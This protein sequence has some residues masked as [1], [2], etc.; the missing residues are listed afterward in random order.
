MPRQ[1]QVVIDCRD[2]DLMATFWAA[3]L[4]YQVDPGCRPAGMSPDQVSYPALT[5]EVVDRHL[6]GSHHIG[7]YPLTDDDTCWWVTAD[8]D[9]D[10]AML[11]AL[12]YVKA[13]RAVGIPAAL[14]V[15]QSGRG[16]HVWIFFATAVSAILARRIATGLLAEAIGL[17]GR[18]SLSSYDRLFP[19][20][21]THTGRDVGNLI[22]APL[23]GARRHPQ[24]NPDL[25]RRESHCTATATSI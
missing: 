10:T 7:L 1:F 17:R 19:S 15:S 24:T 22:A 25:T 12:A 16:A 18:M 6:R 13:A 2:P 14:E 4:A 21:D 23:A 8:F 9:K 11:D 3:A 20:Q 5:A